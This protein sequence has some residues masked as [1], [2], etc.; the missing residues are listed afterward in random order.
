MKLFDRLLLCALIAAI[1]YHG[2]HGN[3]LAGA[4]AHMALCAFLL[5][6]IYVPV[7]AK[8]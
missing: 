4:V 5:C 1:L 8:E 3:P 6:E 2:V 7:R